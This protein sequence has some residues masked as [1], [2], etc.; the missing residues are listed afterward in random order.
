M[1]IASYK[2]ICILK[3]PS[4]KN[5]AKKNLLPDNRAG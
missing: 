5:M 3:P 4:S 1:A 2:K